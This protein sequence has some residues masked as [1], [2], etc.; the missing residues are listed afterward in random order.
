MEIESVCIRSSGSG[1]SKKEHAHPSLTSASSRPRSS[2]SRSAQVLTLIRM[3]P[4]A[5]RM[6]ETTFYRCWGCPL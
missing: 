5:T 2:S 6:D 4:A 1:D 3:G